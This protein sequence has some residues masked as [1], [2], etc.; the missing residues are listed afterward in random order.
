MLS[1]ADVVRDSAGKTTGIAGTV[2]ELHRS[3]YKAGGPGASEDEPA[4]G[5]GDPTDSA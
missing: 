1:E 2:T 3:Y 4:S 5:I